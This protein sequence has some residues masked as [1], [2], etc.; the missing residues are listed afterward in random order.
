MGAPVHSPHRSRGFTLIEL[1]VAL[2]VMA[3]LSLLSW[4][5]I[6]GMVRAQTSMRERTADLASL[7]VG[8]TQWTTDL[9]AVEETG[10]VSGIDFDGTVLR[11]TRRDTAS[12]GGPL[13]VVG[14]TRRGVEGA[15]GRSSW[16]RWQSPPVRTRSELQDGWAQAQRWGQAPGASPAPHEVALTGLDQWQL[17]YYRNNAW[18]NPLSSADAAAPVP[19]GGSGPAVAPLPDAIRLVLTLSSGQAL[20]G[21]LTKDWIR[22]TLGGSKS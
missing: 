9:D 20:T 10:L 8:L 3:T 13:R 19:Q 15:P 14:W 5:G 2:T 4:R 7:Q 16:A 21:V 11:L 12:E 17:F 6:D 1:L 18:S 22:P